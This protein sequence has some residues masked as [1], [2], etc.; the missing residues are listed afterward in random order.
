VVCAACGRES[1]EGFRF[2]GFCGASLPGSAAVSVDEERK[3]V[4]VV[5]CDLVGFTAASEEQDPE[6]VRARLRP[7]HE[8]VREVLE[9]HGATVE[10]YVGDAV[11]AVFG[12]PV[13]HE[14]DAERALRAGLRIIESIA[15][16]NDQDTALDLDVRVGVNTGEAVVT[17]GARP[18]LGD[19][20]VAG[21]VVNTAARVQS[22]AP[23]GSVAVS[24]PTFLAAERVFDFEQLEPVLVKG[25]VQ[26]LRLWRVLQPRARFGADVTRSFASPLVGRELERALLTGALERSAAQRACQLVTIVG[27]P[28]VG[29]SRLCAELF[30]YV[31]ARPGLVRWRQ[32]RC[33]PYG[34]GIAF[35]ALGEIVK[36]ECGI[37]ESD[38][39]AQAAVKLDRA[40]SPTVEDRTWLLARL[41]PLVGI[42]GEPAAQEES[43]AAWRRFVELLAADSPCVLVVDD[44]HWADGA[45]LAF[46]EHV[47]DWAQDV[48]L[49]VLCTARPEL[50]ER[51]PHFGAD[52]RNSQRLNLTPLS[53]E[54]TLQLISALL[55]TSVLPDGVQRAL[56]EHA[57]GNPLY[58]E[59]FVRLLVDRRLVTAPGE[60]ALPDSLQALIAARL[61][62]L[63]PERKTLLQDAAVVG[64]VFWADALVRM[65]DRDPYEVEHALH[66]LA[67]KELVRPVR[68]PSMHGQQEHS[69]WHALVRDVC[70]GQI[71][72]HGR[73]DK[74]LAA[75]AWIAQRAGAHHD[76]LADVLAHHYERAFELLRAARAAS[77]DGDHV[78][79]RAIRYLT[80]AG[81]RALPLD[82]ASAAASLGRALELTEPADPDRPA[83]LERWADATAQAGNLG[84]AESALEEAV[85]RY[86]TVGDRHGEARG[87]I[88]RS[89]LRQR[90]GDTDGAHDAAREALALLRAGPPGPDLVA[91]QI[92]LAAHLAVAG[93]FADALE[94]A[95]DAIELAR[96][97]GH[98][99]P[100]RALGVRGKARAVLGDPGGIVDMRRALALAVERGESRN[101]AV[102]Y[103]N[104]ALEL[105]PYEGPAAA[106][107]A[108]Q[109][110]ID[111]SKRRGQTN[112][113]IGLASQ[114]LTFLADLGRGSDSIADAEALVREGETAGD[115]S[116]TAEARTVLLRETARTGASTGGT[117]REAAA[118]CELVLPTKEPQSIAPAHAT[119]AEANLAHGRTGDARRLLEQV[120]EL[121]AP[122]D[123]YHVAN[124]PSLVRSALRL[125]DIE[126]ASSLVAGTQA[127]TPQA[128]YALASC[129]AQL[130]EARADHAAAA[131][132][133]AAAARG[134]ERHG[135]VPEQAYALFGHGRCLL[136]TEGLASQPLREARRL[137][138]DAGYRPMVAEL[139]TLLVNAATARHEAPA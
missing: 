18:E 45:L 87:L 78:R 85:A 107:A 126:L 132:A 88:L 50:Y 11:M 90:R 9:H 81:D 51:H 122:V 65:G 2:C 94:A 73:A 52:A 42:A 77:D 56:L 46:L 102:L 22:A 44:L 111:F 92:Q 118:L 123:P 121:G 127:L 91:A 64:K 96:V 67:R 3:V 49:L 124:L 19:A 69:F 100:A 134:W 93:H 63:T 60:L 13:A 32:G 23:V 128:E 104:L 8:R 136:A 71:P 138:A 6:D 15:E 37:L 106:L 83:L 54:E 95:D 40:I 57:G 79:R 110:G 97:L 38:S 10:K 28:G 24:E 61:D 80:L 117:L 53:D 139:D 12:A 21:D 25:K 17:V 59:E 84:D 133:Y 125:P 89:G 98:D 86:R 27:E 55:E 135:N 47:A 43:F 137:F 109:Q 30:A 39:A 113:G 105:W 34:E 62:T 130:T 29:K 116:I 4:S 75:A 108:G 99:E 82:V 129:E 14:D 26:P 35:W 72:R 58:A 41:G 5:F 7:Y 74:H 1:P 66:E 131:A 48:S 68:T 120:V 20:F 119:A 103:N 76:D 101:A 31:D 33:L 16:L 112:M 114:N 115:L 70:Y 36:A